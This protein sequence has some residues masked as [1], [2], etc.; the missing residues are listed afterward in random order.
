MYVYVYAHTDMQRGVWWGYVSNFVVII[1][2]RLLCCVLLT[3]WRQGGGDNGST[4]LSGLLQ[5]AQS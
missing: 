4:H 1:N 5:R 2:N 3:L